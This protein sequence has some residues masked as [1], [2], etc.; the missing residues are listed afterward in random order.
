MRAFA[1]TDA[2]AHLINF[3]QGVHPCV[4]DNAVQEALRVRRGQ[5]TVDDDVAA[6]GVR[7]VQAPQRCPRHLRLEERQ[8]SVIAAETAEAPA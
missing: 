5:S 6:Q 8:L 7:V 2:A 4:E 3:G 1:D